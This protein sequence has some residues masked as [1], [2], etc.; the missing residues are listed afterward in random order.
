MAAY[1]IA[2]ITVTDPA[3]YENYKAL[4]PAAIARY[5]GKYLARGGVTEILEG[6]GEDRRVV[7]L[8]FPD[9]NA[10]R[11]FYNSPE[12]AAA[13]SERAGAAEGQFLLVEGL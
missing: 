9:M 6:P 11:S 4:A 5:G 8:E 10:A 7:I 13:K 2:R 12:Y 3:R 1:I